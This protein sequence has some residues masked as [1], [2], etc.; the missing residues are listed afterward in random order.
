[1]PAR[2]A[3]AAFP[4]APAAA[5]EAQGESPPGAD[6]ATEATSRARRDEAPAAAQGAMRGAAP[7]SAKA[8][9]A[10]QSER[11]VPT[12]ARPRLPVAEWVALIRRLRDEGR[13]DDAAKELAA[14]RAAYAD[15]ERRL[16][17]DLRDWKPPETR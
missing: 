7:A 2:R 14:F 1:M 11:G 13:V 16:P 9:A 4:A 6:A 8:S 17:P 10:S 12:E 15:H 3:P 5:S